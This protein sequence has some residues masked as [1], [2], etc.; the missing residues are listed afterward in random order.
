VKIIKS[1]QEIRD[2]SLQQRQRGKKIGFVP[3]MGALHAGHFSLLKRAQELSDISVMSIFVNPTQF[4]PR[5]DYRK[6]PRPFDKDCAAAEQAGCDVMFAPAASDMYPQNFATYVTVEEMG[7]KLCGISRPNHFRGVATVV[8]KFFNII[9]PDVAVFGQKDAQQALLLKR[10]VTD[11]TMPVKLVIAPTVRESD[12]L[13]MSSRNVYLTNAEREQAP[14][15]FKG[16][17]A[18]QRLFE[19]GRKNAKTL[20]NAI[21]E[22]Y[23]KAKQF[24]PEYIEIVDAVRLDPVRTIADTTLIAVACRTS[25][26]STRLIDSIIIG[27]E[28]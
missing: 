28:I 4:G 18:A 24:S 22:V 20:R 15:I 23:N 26:S 3:T 7:K 8:L 1:L 5:E 2:Y 12:G 14:L 27:G 11:L 25:E 21:E 10:M 9:M 16:L 17:T 6:Y 19:S 13:A